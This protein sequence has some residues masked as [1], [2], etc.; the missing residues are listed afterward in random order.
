MEEIKLAYIAG[1][2]DGEGNID[3]SRRRPTTRNP[4]GQDRLQLNVVN[5]Y[6]DSYKFFLSFGGKLSIRGDGYYVWRIS[7][8]K[9]GTFL[10]LIFDYLILKKRQAEYAIEYA[11]TFANGNRLGRGGIL[12]NDIKNKRLTIYNNF[13]KEFT[14]GRADRK[15]FSKFVKEG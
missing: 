10:S 9:A 14:K 2:F 15:K 12:P 6:T 8:K 11:D 3:I 1:F 4:Y 7:G 13:R 5:K